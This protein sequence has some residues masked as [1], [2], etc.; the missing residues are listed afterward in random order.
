MGVLARLI[1]M[2]RLWQAARVLRELQ[3]L[4]ALQAA[5]AGAL[6]RRL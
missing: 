5:Q 6:L 2:V 1:L 4:G 3:A